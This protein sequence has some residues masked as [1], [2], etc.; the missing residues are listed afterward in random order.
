MKTRKL[1]VIMEKCPNICSLRDAPLSRPYSVS[2]ICTKTEKTPSNYKNKLRDLKGFRRKY[3]QTN[4]KPL[5]IGKMSTFK[6]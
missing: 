3:I 1:L 4:S 2:V 5:K 6:D